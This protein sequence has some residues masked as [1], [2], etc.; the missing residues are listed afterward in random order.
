M[1]M[2][3]KLV[4]D[5]IPE[6]IKSE[7]REPIFRTA[8]EKEFPHL[9]HRKLVEEAGDLAKNPTADELS[10]VLEIVLAFAGEMGITW[11]ELESAANR[12]REEKGGFVE[13]IVLKER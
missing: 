12:K 10:D 1:D 8:D 2:K 9:L 11:S 7:G 4:R 6:I 3:E 5:R 13:R